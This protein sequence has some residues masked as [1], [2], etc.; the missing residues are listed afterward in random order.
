MT[1]FISRNF[2]NKEYEIII[3]TDSKE[4]FKATEDFARRLIDHAKPM[5]NADRIRAMSDEELAEFLCDRTEN[6]NLGYCPGAD[7]CNC[8]DGKANGYLKWLKQP[9][10]G[11]MRDG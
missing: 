11:G 2:G 7:L 8:V 10:E 9:A 6:C 1:E 5:T 3:K 4:H